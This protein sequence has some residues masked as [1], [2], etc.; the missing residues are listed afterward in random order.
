MDSERC[1]GGWTITGPVGAAAA[2]LKAR[3]AGGDVPRGWARSARPT[4]RLEAG[5]LLA[6]VG[7]RV[8]LDI[9][10]GLFI[11]SGRLLEASDCP[12]LV[13]DAAAILVAAGIRERWPGHWLEIAGGGEDYELAFVAPPAL[14]QRALSALTGTG[15]EPAV[16]GHFD[17]G[18]GLRVASGSR[19]DAP[20]GSGHQ[21]FRS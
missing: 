20:P 12:G 18:E 21:H 13:I 1:I 5:R 11:D 15:L 16:I 9:S 8:A 14:M 3:E 10:D 2:R 17:A 6:E 7:V 4:P 19:E